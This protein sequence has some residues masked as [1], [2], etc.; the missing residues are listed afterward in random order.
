MKILKQL[1]TYLKQ[2]KKN[3]INNNIILFNIY[4]IRTQCT[5]VTNAIR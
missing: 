3:K 2:G 1:R 4:T 5:V